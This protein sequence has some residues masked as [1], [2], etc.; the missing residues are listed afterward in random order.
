MMM[1]GEH[2]TNSQIK[3]KTLMLKSSRCACSDAFILLKGTITVVGQ[4]A[5]ATIRPTDRNKQVILKN[6]V[7][8]TDY[9]SKINIQV[10]NATDLDVAML[11]YNLTK[12]SDNYSKTAESL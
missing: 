4:G 6:C 11:M 7:S 8:F 2:K 1:S 5:D 10:H 9:I 12:Y 3:F